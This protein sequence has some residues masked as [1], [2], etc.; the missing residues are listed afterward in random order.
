VSFHTS[1]DERLNGSLFA[2]DNDG[3]GAI[4]PWLAVDRKRR[5]TRGP[6]TLSSGFEADLRGVDFPEMLP[7]VLND[8]PLFDESTWLD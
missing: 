3:G 4:H 6:K 1:I 7:E 5:V 2:G 8:S